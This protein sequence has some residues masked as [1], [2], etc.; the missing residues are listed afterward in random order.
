MLIDRYDPLNLFER[1]PRLGMQMDPLLAQIDHLLDQDAIFQ[2]V[3]ADL[4]RRYPHPLTVGRPSPPVEVI[5]RMLGGKHRYGWSFE[6]TEHFVADSL[7]LRQT[8]RI[9]AEQVPDDTTLI[10]WAKLIP[11]APLQ[12]WL[13]H[14][15][16]LARQLKVTKGRKLRSDGTVVATNLD[17]PR[18]S[19]LLND[20]VRGRSRVMRTARQ[21]ATDTVG[22]SQAPLQEAATAAKAGMKRIMDVARKTGDAAAD[23]LK[24]A[25]QELLVL[26]QT[27]VEQAQ[28]TAQALTSAANATAQRCADQLATMVLRVEQVIQQ[29]TRRVLQGESV[30]APEQILSV[31]EPHTAIRCKGKPGKPVE[32]GRVLWLDQVEGGIITR[33]QLLD[34]N[35]D[36]AAQGRPS[37]DAHIQRLGHPPD[38]VAG[39]RGLQSVANERDL[40]K[41]KLAQIVLP[42]PGNKSAQRLAQKR[43]DWCIAGRNWR[44]GIEGRIS[45][46]KRRHQLNRCRYHGNA[47]MH[48]WVGLGLRAHELRTIARATA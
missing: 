10:R 8:C 20:G 30:P 32:F 29:T 33:Y 12:T 41:R 9:Y 2:A 24:P 31:F 7:V 11:P 40:A 42:K 19:R 43:Q 34:G 16:A 14:V 36:E 5:L 47:G 44:A 22:W 48:R 38:L 37:V 23:A 28:Q 3:K 6:A 46:L 21:V 18:D 17:Q 45:G 25:Y 1:I 15:T 13:D 35:P 26:S 4:A 39:D 27:V